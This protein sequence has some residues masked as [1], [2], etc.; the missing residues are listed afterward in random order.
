MLDL[1]EL[2]TCYCRDR[3]N[4]RGLVPPRELSIEVFNNIQII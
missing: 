3:L 1:K 4:L 2:L